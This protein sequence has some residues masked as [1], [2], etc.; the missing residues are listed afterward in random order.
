MRLRRWP[1][2]WGAVDALGVLGLALALLYLLLATGDNNFLST[3]GAQLLPNIATAFAGVWLSVRIIDRIIRRRDAREHEAHWRAVHGFIYARLIRL[4][5][6][7][8]TSAVPILE[9]NIVGAL[10]LQ[11]GGEW[12][13]LYCAQD[14]ADWE[15]LTSRIREFEVS[16]VWPPEW[17]NQGDRRSDA[18]AKARGDLERILDSFAHLLDPSLLQLLMQFDNQLRYLDAP[19][20]DKEIRI[21][22]ASLVHTASQ[23]VAELRRRADTEMSNSDY[24]TR[25][26]NEMLRLR[27]LASEIQNGSA[28]RER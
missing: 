11:F 19:G 2:S 8:L 13:D 1:G 15:K 14:P 6:N 22:L 18:I 28:S 3:P 21:G 4:I 10:V 25:L 16:D 27:G 12:A 17:L 26:A 24:V 20:W 5:D 9:Q 23:V 7:L